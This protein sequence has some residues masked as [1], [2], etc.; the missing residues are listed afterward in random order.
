MATTPT[1]PGSQARRRPQNDIYTVL[2]IIAGTFL[3]GAVA[4]IIY[5]LLDLYGTV[6]PPA[7]G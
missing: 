1:P 6:F 2:L 7:G 3:V 5:R 4:F